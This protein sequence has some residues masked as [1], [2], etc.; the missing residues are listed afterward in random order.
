MKISQ[1]WK[2]K[3]SIPAE[4]GVGFGVY[5]QFLQLATGPLGLGPE[6]KFEKSSQKA[7]VFAFDTVTTLSFEPTS[8]FIDDAI[9]A[10]AVQAYLQEPKQ[11][12]SPVVSLFLVTGLKVVKGAKVTYATSGTKKLTGNIGIDVAPLSITANL[13][14]YW[15]KINDDETEFSRDSEFIFAFRVKRL[16][17]GRKVEA[18]EYN[19]GAL[20]AIGGNK[21]S[22][23]EYVLVDDMDGTQI[24]SATLIPDASESSCS[25]WSWCRGLGLE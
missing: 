3:K 14:A 8:E 22:G 20:L 13:K 1:W 21:T 25:V 9:K 6:V 7:D 5:A 2:R 19:K 12:F 24:P 11:R 15:T 18:K 10:P 4:T 16:R 23:M 17:F